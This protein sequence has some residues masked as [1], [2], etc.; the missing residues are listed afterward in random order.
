MIYLLKG[1]QAYLHPLNSWLD[2][3]PEGEGS[4]LTLIWATML[5]Y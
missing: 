2:S 3:I 5:D 4:F 1:I